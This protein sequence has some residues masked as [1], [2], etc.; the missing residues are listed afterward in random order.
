MTILTSLVSAPGA[1]AD[2]VRPTTADQDAAR[3][4]VVQ[5]IDLGSGSG[6]TGGP[7][8]PSPPS[9]ITCA[10]FGPKRVELVQTG[11]AE[12]FFSATGLQF[13]SHAQVLQTARMVSLDWQR[14]VV[15]RA[16]L[17][18]LAAA[19]SSHLERGEK[20]VSFNRIPFP[21]VGETT[22]AFRGVIDLKGSGHS[23]RLA[24]DIVLFTTGRATLDLTTTTP[25]GSVA[26]VR[27]DEVALARDM[28]GR[29]AAASDIA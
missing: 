10:A 1:L 25:L 3:L 19:F 23:V 21:P 9:P 7:V 13:H 11:S 22:A 14:T 18:C 16:V 2:T 8:K 12:S 27:P 28:A 24:I 6:W 26:L 20:V 15:P 17:P 29:A 4:M 5:R